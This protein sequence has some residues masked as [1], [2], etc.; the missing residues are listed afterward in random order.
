METLKKLYN[1]R[2]EIFA[3]KTYEIFKHID[4]TLACVTLYLTD[5]DDMVAQGIIAW[6][7]TTL[8]EDLVVVIGTVQYN[9]GEFLTIDNKEIEITK[10]NKEKYEQVVHMSIPYDLVIED[11]KDNIIEF[12]Y[13]VGSESELTH[14][15]IPIETNNDFDLTELSEEQLTAL[16][17]NQSTRDN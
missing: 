13:T 17:T 3:D 2:D 11:D 6:E 4:N 9:V 7:D 8:V 5:I 16:Q 14:I 1:V 12:L 15:G 10:D